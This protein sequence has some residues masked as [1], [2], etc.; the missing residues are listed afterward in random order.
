LSKF[1]AIFVKIT[2]EYRAIAPKSDPWLN[3]FFTSTIALCCVPKLFKDY[4][5]FS[6]RQVAVV[7]P[8]RQFSENELGCDY[9]GLPSDDESIVLSS[10]S[11]YAPSVLSGEGMCIS[12]K[13]MIG[14]L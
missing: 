4:W 9:D 13:D 6:G 8:S 3:I 10:G 11:S 5:K 2:R 14:L 12:H 7:D 1:Y